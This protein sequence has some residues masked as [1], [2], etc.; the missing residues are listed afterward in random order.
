[1]YYFFSETQNISKFL[2]NTELD[3]VFQRK[4][5]NQNVLAHGSSKTIQKFKKNVKDG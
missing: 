5:K 1:M 3:L 4:N 2:E